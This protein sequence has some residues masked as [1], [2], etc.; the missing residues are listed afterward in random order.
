MIGISVVGF[1]NSGKTTLT[2]ELAKALSHRGLNVAG[3]KFSHSRLDKPDTDTGR[4]A[5]FCSAVIGLGQGESM[6][7]WPTER[8]LPDLLPLAQA[9]ALVV[10]GGKSL[11]WLPRVLVLREGDDIENL[12]PDLALG[13][14]GPITAPGLPS[15]TTPDDVARA[16][17]DRGFVLPG[18][19]CGACGRESCRGLAV[20]IVANNAT[21]RD[22]QARGGGL[23]V[24]VGGSQLAMNPFVGRVMRGALTGVLAELKGYAPGQPVVIEFD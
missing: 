6:V 22:C 14:Y 7:L 21:A 8:F 23:T 15:F 3:A 19:D 13:T 10:E 17:M 4:L 18:L 20:D 1:K 24:T 12:G 16:A 5:E 2:L 11:G 9:E